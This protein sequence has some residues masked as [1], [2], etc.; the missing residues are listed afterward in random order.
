MTTKTLREIIRP[1]P[2]DAMIASIQQFIVSL[3]TSPRVT[4]VALKGSLFVQEV[5]KL[6]KEGVI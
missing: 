3:P 5:R 6:Q 1:E 4:Q 2:G